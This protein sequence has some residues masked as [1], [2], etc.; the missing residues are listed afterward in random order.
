MLHASRG[1]QGF[2]ASGIVIV[3]AGLLA[4][5]STNHSSALP[6][7]APPPA[8]PDAEC[9]RL[10]PVRYG[11][12]VLRRAQERG[13]ARRERP[14]RCA[15]PGSARGRHPC[16][17]AR[18]AEAVAIGHVRR[19]PGRHGGRSRVQLH[20]LEACCARPSHA[21][22]DPTR[23]AR[24]VRQGHRLQRRPD[25]PHGRLHRPG[26]SARAGRPLSATAPAT[27]DQDGRRTRCRPVQSVHAMSAS[28]CRP[29]VRLPHG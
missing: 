16:A 13:G 1:R 22:A 23:A 5:A 7:V 12:S 3:A 15:G 6:Q 4:C 11:R 18:R 19:G 20:G 9:L 24:G 2:G 25:L 26:S 28:G 8:D 14:A 21:T 29:P 10:G 17:A 27:D